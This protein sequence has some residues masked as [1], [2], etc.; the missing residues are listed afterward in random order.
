MNNSFEID[1]GVINTLYEWATLD[2]IA[3]NL[4]T[5]FQRYMWAKVK[6]PFSIVRN[7]KSDIGK[8]TICYVC[9]FLAQLRFNNIVLDPDMYRDLEDKAWRILF[10][11]AGLEGEA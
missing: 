2:N 3:D 9:D 7:K 8:L 1:I 4:S 6:P 5:G 11:I 10:I